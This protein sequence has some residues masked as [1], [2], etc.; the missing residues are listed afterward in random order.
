M[1]CSP[2]SVSEFSAQVNSTDI[3]SFPHAPAVRNQVG[4]SCSS[5]SRSLS[6]SKSIQA[7]MV[8]PKGNQ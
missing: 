2:A 6:L 1:Q 7:S 3:H 5:S 4:I 8:I